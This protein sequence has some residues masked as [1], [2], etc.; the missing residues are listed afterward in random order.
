MRDTIKRDLFRALVGQI[1]VLRHFEESLWGWLFR[2]GDEKCSAIQREID[3]Y[4]AFLRGNADLDRGNPG[5][6]E[7]AA[8][9]LIAIFSRAEITPDLMVEL[10][11]SEDALAEHLAGLGGDTLATASALRQRLIREGLRRVARVIVLA[12]IDAPE[13]RAKIYARLLE[14]P[15]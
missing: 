5:A 2:R 1:P 8:N 6:A 13:Y 14:R 7:S 11:F 12:T 9:D 15:G 4:C 3:G 10:K